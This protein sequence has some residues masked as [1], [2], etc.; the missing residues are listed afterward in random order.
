MNTP[1]L[2]DRLSRAWRTL[3]TTDLPTKSVSLDEGGLVWAPARGFGPPFSSLSSLNAP[4]TPEVM[5]NSYSNSPWAHVKFLRL[6]SAVAML[7]F[8]IKARRDDGTSD[9]LREDYPLWTLLRDPNPMLTG[10]DFT[11]LTELY[12]RVTGEVYW[13]IVRNGLGRPSELWVLP[14]F[15]VKVQRD[16]Q[17]RQVMFYTI[18][19]QREPIP[20]KD[21]IWLH[22]PMPTNPYLEGVGDMLAMAT[23]IETFEYAS[24]ADRTLMLKGAVP[25][26]ILKTPGSP[27]LPDRKAM[28]EEWQQTYGG[29]G[30]AGQIAILWGG[31][32]FQRIQNTKKEMDFVES[33]K[34]LRDVIIAGVHPHILGISE[35]V[36]RAQA[37]AAEYTFARWEILPRARWHE[38]VRNK[39]LAPQFDPRAFVEFQNVVPGDADRLIA[40]ALGPQSGEALTID[41]RITM[42][43]Q[44]LGT[45]DLKA[46]GGVYGGSYILPAIRVPF[47]AGA[48]EN[49]EAPP[50]AP[51]K[52]EEENPAPQA[53]KGRAK[54]LTRQKLL[55][56]Q[57]I[58]DIL[59]T[60]KV[61]LSDADVQRLRENFMA[62]APRQKLSLQD[63]QRI[64]GGVTE[65]AAFLYAVVR[66]VYEQVME[67]RW[68]QVVEELGLD[69]G[70]DV[71]DPEVA[72]FLRTAAGLRIRGI[73]ETTL[74]TLRDTL[75]EGVAA[76]EGI[77]DLARR[78]TAVFESAK[79]P[80]AVLIARTETLEA[81]NKA[82]HIAYVKAG[83]EFKEWLLAPDYTPE[84]DNGECGPF[85]GVI[86]PIDQEFAPG[87]M[88]PPLHVAC[89]CALAASFQEG[90]GEQRSF[91]RLYQGDARKAHI[92]A[93][94]SF[95]AR[96]ERVMLSAVKRGF[97][98]QQNR[99]SR[100]LRDAA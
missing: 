88:Y 32:E 15:W 39:F 94:G 8:V 18:P 46:P 30:N 20:P 96:L 41:Q 93:L 13:R 97:Q 6:C 11:F 89:R 98:E 61:D 84:I 10:W 58:D 12:I 5:L 85:D 99:I 82:A 1:T 56:R 50:N 25:P 69:I 22:T 65:E 36:N 64:I 29:P 17:T 23:E 86:I 49:G 73:T 100:R 76:G 43:G 2:I 63:I 16:R 55:S 47:N 24:E 78:I 87:I 92:T 28:R 37:E 81:S 51:E 35:G 14:K 27:P 79:G 62:P 75:A 77:P 26:G 21:M 70:F 38:G 80:R 3:T 42:L 74:Q 68:E 59:L 4:H 52:P 60:F 57:D 90:E 9:I 33:Q 31:L 34:Y 83:I 7:D 66:A 40:A 72:A 53:P 95:H 67:S 19:F 48:P 91:R 54:T 45:P 44:A 71:T